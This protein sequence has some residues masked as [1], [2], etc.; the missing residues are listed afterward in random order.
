MN[1]EIVHYV[2]TVIIRLTRLT[3]TFDDGQKNGMWKFRKINHEL[4]AL[5]G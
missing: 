4:A 3:T 2:Q 1:L 5:Y